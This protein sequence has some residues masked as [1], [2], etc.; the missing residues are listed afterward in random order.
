MKQHITKE[1]SFEIDS[2]VLEKTFGSKIVNIGQMIQFL[3]DDILM[4]TNNVKQAKKY[5]VFTIL[6]N[7]KRIFYNEELADALWEATKYKLKNPQK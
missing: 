3:G 5:L 6:V 7:F 1:Q 4:I 2:K